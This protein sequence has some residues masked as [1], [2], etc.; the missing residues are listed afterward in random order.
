MA[1]EQPRVPIMRDDSKLMDY[2]RELIRFL[3]SFTQAAWNSDRVNSEKIAAIEERLKRLE[4][5]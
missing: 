5:G 4:G 1:Y 3:R 2:I